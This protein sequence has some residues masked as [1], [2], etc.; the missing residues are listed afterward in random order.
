MRFQLCKTSD[1][2]PTSN[3]Y[4]Y[5]PKID[6]ERIIAI[7]NGN[8]VKLLNRN[9]KTN[10][11]QFEKSKQYPE[12]VE[13][14]LAQEHDFILDGEIAC[15]DLRKGIN[16]FNQRALQTNPFKI[17]MLIEKIPIKYFVF[18]IL[19]VNGTNVTELPLVERKNILNSFLIETK[20]I[21]I[22]KFYHNPKE[23]WKKVK[24][25]QLEGMVAKLKNS[26]Y[27]FERNS[28]WLK[29][30]NYD[31]MI[32][33]CLGYKQDS[34]R[35]KFGSLI[36]DR[37]NVSLLTEENKR[38]YLKFKPKKVKVRYYGIYPSGKLRNPV[39]LGWCV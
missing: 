6:G 4:I 38:F 3:L 16:V 2:I 30:K 12:I 7:K 31:E 10:E 18:D 1:K 19:Q 9:R 14:L 21:E 24:R 15:S 36:T 39:F 33:N 35:S 23:L 27:R 22:V 26:P 28:N 11:Y 37:C 20:H 32:V 29:I 13:E 5:E 8:S 25:N 17:K 34:K